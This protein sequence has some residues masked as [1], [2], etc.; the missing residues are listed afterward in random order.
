MNLE[1]FK[2]RQNTQ[3]LLISQE[4]K[5]V[6]I[7]SQTF[8]ML[9]LI[10]TGSRFMKKAILILALVLFFTQ[11][12]WA[13]DLKVDKGNYRVGVFGSINKGR[14]AGSDFKGEVEFAL[15]F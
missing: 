6:D 1:L 7:I 9:A 13:S 15:F 14:L 11:T 4:V 3:K 2:T 12:L 5:V 8:S 10:I